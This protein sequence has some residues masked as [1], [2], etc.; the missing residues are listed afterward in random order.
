MQLALKQAKKK[1]KTEKDKNAHKDAQG[2]NNKCSSIEVFNNK[3][4]GTRKNINSFS[5]RWTFSLVVHLMKAKWVYCM[6]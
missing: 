3:K 5:L 1:F 6:A 4:F 2:L